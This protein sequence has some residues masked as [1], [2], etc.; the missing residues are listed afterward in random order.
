[1]IAIFA[2]G[3]VTGGVI[4]TKTA[5]NDLY[6]LPKGEE[7]CARMRAKLQ[8]RLD[9]TP[10]QLRQIDPLIKEATSQLQSIHRDTVKRTSH[11]MKE[12]YGR[13]S[14]ALDPQQRDRLEALDR[15]RQDFIRKRCRSDGDRK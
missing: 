1:M 2:A 8:S 14:P 11:A 5:R 4:A 7:M 15:E 10:D 3:A 12:C 13:M 6:R 9:L